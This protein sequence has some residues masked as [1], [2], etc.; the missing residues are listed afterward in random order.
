MDA[1]EAIMTRRSI[2]KYTDEPIADEMMKQI[3]SAA[4]AAPTAGNQQAWEFVVI[5][6]RKVLNA[7]PDVHP[8]SRMLLV[9]PAAILVCGNL[10]TETKEGYYP[11]DCA[12]ATQNILLAA[13]ALGLGAVWLGVHPRQERVTGIRKLLNIPEHVVPVALVALGHPAES[14]PRVDRYDEKKVHKDTW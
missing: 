11:Q 13:H 1:V 14:H 4:M 6:D 3:L 9:A 8:Y 2:R 12:A 10:K 7:L 5:T